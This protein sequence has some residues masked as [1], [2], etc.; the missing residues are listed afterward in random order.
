[1]EAMKRVG[2]VLILGLGLTGCGGKPDPILS[3]AFGYSCNTADD[4]TGLCSQRPP[5]AGAADVSRYCYPSIGDA[6]CFDR[7]DPDRKNQ[8]QG[9]SGY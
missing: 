5:G 8:E 4:N 1:M 9:S 2:V 3:Q 7:P 6:S